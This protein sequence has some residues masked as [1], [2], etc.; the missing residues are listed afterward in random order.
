MVE[1][2]AIVIRGGGPGC[3]LSVPLRGVRTR[4]DTSRRS[5]FGHVR[6]PPGHLGHRAISM[7]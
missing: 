5:E 6:T 2:V 4:T 1:N 7:A 3:P